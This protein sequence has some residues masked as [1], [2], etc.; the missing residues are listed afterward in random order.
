MSLFFPVLDGSDTRVPGFML[1]APQKATPLQENRERV[2]SQERRERKERK[3]SNRTRMSSNMARRREAGRVCWREKTMATCDEIGMPKRRGK[4]EGEERGGGRHLYK[5][6][7]HTRSR[8]M[9]TKS[10]IG[11][12][13]ILHMEVV[14]VVQRHVF[15]SVWCRLGRTAA[16][17][18]HVPWPVSTCD[19]LVSAASGPRNGPRN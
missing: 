19:W 3:A 1:F 15:R 9:S 13:R 11:A 12:L 8:G 18:A 17:C 16:E 7:Q 4:W 10:K 14:V 6:N 5:K 2:E